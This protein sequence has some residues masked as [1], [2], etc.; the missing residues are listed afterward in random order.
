MTLAPLGVV[1]V[2]YNSADVILDCLET[3]FAAA[4]AD[5]TVLRVV[6]VDNA[7]PDD[8]VSAIRAWASGSVPFV[9]PADLPFPHVA[10]PKPLPDGKLE[11][12]AAG[13]NGG[14]AA[15]VNIGLRRLFADPA[16]DRVWILN[17]DSVVPPGTPA[18][19]ARHDPGPFSLMGGRVFYYD[20]P[21]MI[22]T[23]G[24]TLN[25]WTGVTGNV[26]LSKKSG[27]AV[28]PDPEQVDFITG[29]SMVASRSF[30]ELAGPMPENYFLYY[31]EV[32]WALRREVLP[33]AMTPHAVMFHRA[34]SAIGSATLERT[35]SSFS[36]YFKSRS[37]I[38]FTRRWYPHALPTALLYSIAKMAQ[39]CLKRQFAEARAI[40]D[41]IRGSLPQ[42]LVL[43]RLSEEASRLVFA[44]ERERTSM[45]GRSIQKH[46]DTFLQAVRQYGLIPTCRTR[47]RDFTLYLRRLYLVKVWKMDIHPM[48]LVSMQAKLDRTF[49][50]GVHIGEGSAV[51][52][53]AVILTH[54]IVVGKHTHTYIGKY[55]MVGARSIVMPGL[56]VGDHS[57]I[58]AGAVVTKDVPANSIVAGNPAKVIRTGIMTTNWGKITERGTKPDEG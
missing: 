32:D 36:I 3:L 21:D 58:A 27:E 46:P 2:A 16:I 43:Q 7:S 1:L 45:A 14:F 31:E 18:A 48:T 49:P 24:G 57:V 41:G 40:W 38:W 39:F 8:G 20:P 44:K 6:V 4:M 26:N 15:G 50:R 47:L 9:P 22:Q 55:C 37:R 42:D 35:A 33:L 19:F 28:F 52:F 29:A 12:I 5:G 25:R 34:G 11:I 53:D 23:D 51:N 54:D 30:W 56:R 10:V 17:P 13:L